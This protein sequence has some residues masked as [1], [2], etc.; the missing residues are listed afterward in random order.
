MQF[1]EMQGATKTILF[2]QSNWRKTRDNNPFHFSEF[3]L[4]EKGTL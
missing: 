3:Y 4:R 1:W 2:V